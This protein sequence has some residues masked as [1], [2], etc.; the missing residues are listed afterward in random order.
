[1]DC[2]NKFR[3]FLCNRK[4][5]SPLI[6]RNTFDFFSAAADRN[7]TKL[8]RKQ[9][10]N[11]LYQVCVFRVDKKRRWPPS[12]LNG[13]NIFD[14]FLAAAER[15]STKLVRKQDLNVHY[16]FCIFRADKM[17]APSASDWLIHFR[18]LCN[19]WTEFNDTWQDARSQSPLLPREGPGG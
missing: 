16:H 19:R 1:M 12:P 17:V 3:L 4:P 7:S 5:P 14:F 18:R 9:D 6:Y 2:E 10:L 13:R 15:N 8:V 11:V